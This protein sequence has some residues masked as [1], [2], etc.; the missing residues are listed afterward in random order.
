[1][2]AS[3][4]WANNVKD[5]SLVL[6]TMMLAAHAVGLASCWINR[7]DAMF[8]SAEGK[9]IMKDLNLPEGLVG[10]GALALGYADGAA[11]APKPRKK[12][13]FRVIK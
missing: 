4:D 11:H 10:I 6:G 7:E 3:A 12:D 2:F 8:E 1:V 5:G 9:A 13:Y